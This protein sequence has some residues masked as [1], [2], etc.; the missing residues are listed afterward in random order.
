VRALFRRSRIIGRRFRLVHVLCG[1]EMVE[2]S[3]FRGTSS[4]AA[5]GDE[6]Q[7]VT[8][9]HGRI[10]RDN[11]FGSLED[12]AR[13]RDFTIN[14]LFY[15]PVREEVRDYP[16]GTAALKARKLRIMGDAALRYGEAPGGMLRGARRAAPLDL[17]IEPHSRKPIRE[18]ADL[19]HN[20]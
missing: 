19:L 3:T 10:L 17:E 11:V 4:G 14:A 7:H 20:V 15:D 18:M 8:D 16:R 5:E 1:S 6:Q 12:D 9:E 13:R 2:V